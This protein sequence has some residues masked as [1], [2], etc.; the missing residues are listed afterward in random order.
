MGPARRRSAAAAAAMALVVACGDDDVQAP[1]GRGGAGGE[2]AG[3]GG[4]V[5]DCGVLCGTAMQLACDDET[6]APSCVM[7]HDGAG[8]C[9]ATFAAYIACLAAHADEIVSPCTAWPFACEEEH[10]AWF[11]CG[12]MGPGCGPVECPQAGDGECLCQAVCGGVKYAERCVETETGFACACD[13]DGERA[14]T[15][16]EETNACAFFVGCCAPVLP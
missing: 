7:A 9:Q 12:G 8:E 10:D 3:A 11:A 1:D 2:A 4:I 6:C 16:A 15:C 5:G 13:I 14:F